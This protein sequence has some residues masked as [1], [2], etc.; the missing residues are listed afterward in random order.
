MAELVKQ[1]EHLFH[2]QQHWLAGGRLR[3]IEDVADNRLHAEQRGLGHEVVHPRATI[4]VVASEEVRIEQPEVRIRRVAH[5]EHAHLRMVDGEV[6]ALHDGQPVQ[7]LSGIE[8]AV[9]HH[10]LEFEIRR[11]VCRGEVVLRFSDLLRVEL[12]VP[13]LDGCSVSVRTRQRLEVGPLGLGLGYGGGHELSQEH[14]DPIGALRHLVVQPPCR[15]VGLSQELGAS[16]A[17]L[18]EAADR[19]AGVVRVAA[20][21]ALGGRL[22][23][24]FA[25]RAAPQRSQKRLLRGVD[26]GQDPSPIESSR[27]GRGRCV[28][29]IDSRQSVELGGVVHNQCTVSARREQFRQELGAECRLFLV[30]TLERSLVTVRETRPRQHESLMLNLEETFRLHVERKRLAFAVHGFDA[31]KQLRVQAYRV[32]VPRERGRDV[33]LQLLEDVVRV[34]AGEHAEHRRDTHHGLATLF[35]RHQRVLER[36]CGRIVRDGL[37]LSHLQPHRLFERRTE[38]GV[39]DRVEGRRLKG[40]GAGG[41]Q[42]V[43]TTATLTL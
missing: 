26:Q 14:F 38:I 25:C 35:E 4:L 36:R 1:C 40:E 29:D 19:R 15:V 23:Q 18:G 37:D 42:R 13:C 3:Q 32:V 2:A 8:H 41:Q 12:P 28:G 33:L 27:C 20:R 24:P 5:F 6:M 7:L 22:E 30:E 31:R 11:Q 34:R 9:A 21:G 17:N 16:C 10:A 39:R 43:H